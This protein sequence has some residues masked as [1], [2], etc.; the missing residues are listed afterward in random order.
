MNVIGLKGRARVGKSTAAQYLINRGYERTSFAAPLKLMLKTLLEYQGVAPDIVWSMLNGK[1]KEEPTEF[2]SG[3]SPRE[4][5]Q[6]LGTEWGRS[7]HPDLWVNIWKNKVG[8]SKVCVDDMR[9]SNEADAVRELGGYVIEIVPSKKD[10]FESVGISGHASET[11]DFD[12]DIVVV[13]DG[14]SLTR[15][16][17]D[18]NNALHVLSQEATE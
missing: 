8:D 16:A 18:L 6:T 7:F 3:K 12:P 17:S 4:A 2:L 14:K 13:N 5:M 15:Y 10:A 1:L 9:F 11:L